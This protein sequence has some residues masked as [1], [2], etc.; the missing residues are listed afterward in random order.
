MRILSLTNCPVQ[1]NLGSGKTVLM[2]TQ[3]LSRLGHTV[4]VVQP[5]DFET[6]PGL[7]KAKKFRLAWGALD[8]AR[9]KLQAQPY[10]LMECYG[11]EFWLAT[12][13]VSQWPKRPL[14]VAH[15]NGLELLAC[16]I[17]QRSFPPQTPPECLYAWFSKQTHQRFSR[18]AFSYADAFV[19]LCETD[20]QYV[21]KQG[22][23]LP[24]RTAVVEPGLDEEYLAVPFQAQRAERLAFMGS[25]IPRKGID[26]LC[27]VMSRL[28][29]EQPKLH[30]DLYGTGAT[31]LTVLGGFP[32]SVRARITVH[33]C[34]SN[35]EIAQGLALA[36]V[37]FFPSHYE[38][39][40]IALAEAMACGCAVVTTRTGFGADLDD[41]VQALLCDV[42]DVG[43]M[44][45]AVSRLLTDDA[46]RL[47]IAAGGRQRVRAMTWQANVE[48]LAAVYQ[49]W[50]TH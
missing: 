36:K 49:T 12:W 9:R 10:D 39:F 13:Q 5:R 34:L 18:M 41:G 33:P 1:A 27:T 48:K 44:E 42:L 22:L 26:Q 50:L 3:G 31:P 2:Y 20:R 46:L 17:E 38:G 4:E 32:E 35:Q 29:V 40:G 16:A 8:L 19:A 43:A 6:W 7:R 45:R 21:L 25:W 24:E 11:D 23:Y 15:T 37:F 28:L 30:L 47:K 14:L